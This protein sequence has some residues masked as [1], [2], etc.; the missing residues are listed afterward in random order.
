MIE[1]EYQNIGFWVVYYTESTSKPTLYIEPYGIGWD[2]L[3]GQRYYVC[4][5]EPPPINPMATYHP[6][7][8]IQ[9]FASEA[10]VY[11]DSI[12]LWPLE[13]SI[14]KPPVFP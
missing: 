9:V 3:P 13:P 10:I 14:E 8:D 5:K 2:M 4:M 7:G 1:A 12:Q 11:L 6:N